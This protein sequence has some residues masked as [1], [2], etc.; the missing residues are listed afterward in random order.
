MQIPATGSCFNITTLS[1]FF[2][3]PTFVI[4]PPVPCNISIGHKFPGLRLGQ[5]VPQVGQHLNHVRRMDVT[6]LILVKNPKGSK[7]ISNFNVLFKPHF[8]YLNDARRSS[9]VHA[10]SCC[11]DINCRNSLNSTVS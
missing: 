11:L 4:N 3:G 5:P 6:I 10:V 1:L 7:L 8:S 9:R 2:F